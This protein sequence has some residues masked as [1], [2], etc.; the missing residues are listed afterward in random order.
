MIFG[1]TDYDADEELPYQ[2]Y[3]FGDVIDTRDISQSKNMALVV[4]YE[5][6]DLTGGQFSINQLAFDANDAKIYFERMKTLSK[7]CINDITDN[8]SR[9]WH[10]YPTRGS[11]IWNEISK[12]YPKRL[13][14]ETLPPIMHFALYT[15]EGQ[16]DREQCIKSPRV[17]FIV[18]SHGIIYPLFYDPYHEMNSIKK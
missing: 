14:S 8:D 2:K 6:M 11:K 4:C 13:T 17:H 7:S 18:G 10:L 5:Y 16:A 12:L 9:Q 1:G 15:C 3:R